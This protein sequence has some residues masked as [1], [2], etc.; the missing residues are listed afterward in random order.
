MSAQREFNLKSQVWFQTKIAQ[1][2]VQLPLYY[3]HF[4]IIAHYLIT[5]IQDFSQ[6]QYFIDPVAVCKKVEPETI[7]HLILYAKQKVQF[8]KKKKEK[9]AI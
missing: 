9:D 4:K 2:K 5:Q 1:H 8:Q 3:I 7:L 6:Y